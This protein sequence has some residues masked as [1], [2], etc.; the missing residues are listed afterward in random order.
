MAYRTGDLL[1]QGHGFAMIE[2]RSP[3]DK[4]R[5]MKSADPNF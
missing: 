5:L 2:R 3:V 1:R 4:P